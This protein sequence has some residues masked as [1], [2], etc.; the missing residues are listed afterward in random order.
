VKFVHESHGT[1]NQ[2]LLYWLGRA[3]I[4]Q[5]V[6]GYLNNLRGHKGPKRAKISYT[7]PIINSE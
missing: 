5:S 6:S 1:R 2:K 3:E 7:M 4:Q